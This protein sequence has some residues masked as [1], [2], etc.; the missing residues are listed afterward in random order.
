MSTCDF[1]TALAQASDPWVFIRRAAWPPSQ[2]SLYGLDFMAA[3]PAR[4]SL[5]REDVTAN[6]W[7]LTNTPSEKG[8]SRGE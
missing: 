1:S 6:D 7:V 5:T 2:P 8:I 3:A 4:P